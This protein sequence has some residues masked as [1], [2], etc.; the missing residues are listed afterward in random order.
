MKCGAGKC[1]NSMK[2]MKPKKEPAMKCGAG[3][4][5]NNCVNL[6]NYIYLIK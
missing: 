5:K 2:E 1:G 6:K 4:C 3:E